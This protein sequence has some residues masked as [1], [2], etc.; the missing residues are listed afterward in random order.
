MINIKRLSSLDPHFYEAL[1]ALL[2]FETTQDNVI[3]ETVTRILSE[4][5]TQGDREYTLRARTAHASLPTSV[6]SAQRSG[7]RGA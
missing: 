4:I 1:D 7:K 3:I 5:R 6:A 2:A